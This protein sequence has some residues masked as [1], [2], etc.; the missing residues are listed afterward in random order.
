MT[1]MPAVV[2][3]AWTALA[4][5]KALG[6]ASRLFRMRPR[7]GVDC[8]AP[9][10]CS[11]AELLPPRGVAQ[12]RLH[13][14]V[15]GYSIPD[16]IARPR[17]IAVAP[18]NAA[19][20]E[21]VS[22]TAAAGQF[23]ALPAIRGLHC[24]SS[25]FSPAPVKRAVCMTLPDGVS[26]QVAPWWIADLASVPSIPLASAPVFRPVSD[27][28]QPRISER[29][30][31]ARPRA[32]VI[33]E[34]GLAAVPCAAAEQMPELAVPA[35]ALDVTR[36]APQRIDRLFRMRPRAGITGNVAAFTG[37][38]LALA[39]DGRR[40]AAMPRPLRSVIGILTEPPMVKRTLRMRPRGP[41]GS[42]EL[43]MVIIPAAPGGAA[44]SHAYPSAP[45]DV[46]PV[47]RML[48]REYRM[49]PRVGVG[50]QAPPPHVLD[51]SA[52]GPRIS[53]AVPQLRLLARLMPR[54]VDRLYRMRPRTGINSA[55]RTPERALES[56]PLEIVPLVP[57][58]TLR[59]CAPQMSARLYRMRPRNPISC[60]SVS[61]LRL[62]DM[63]MEEVSEIFVMPPVPSLNVVRTFELPRSEKP[64]RLNPPGPTAATGD[65]AGLSGPEPLDPALVARAILQLRFPTITAVIGIVEP[66]KKWQRAARLTRSLLASYF[67]PR[68]WHPAPALRLS[69]CGAAVLTVILIYSAPNSSASSGR[70]AVAQARE[71]STVS[72]LRKTLN[73]RSA[74]DLTESFASGLHDW[75]GGKDWAASW[76]Y[77]D[78]GGVKPGALALYKPSVLLR[79]YTFEFMGQIERKALAFVTRAADIQNYYVVKLVVTRPGPLPEISIVRY[80][81]LEGREAKHVEK[82]LV[83]TVY[84]DAIYRVRTTVQGDTWAFAVNDQVVDSWTDDRL[85]AGGVGLF[86]AKGEKARIY[87]LRVRHQDDT[88]GKVLATI[89]DTGPQATRGTP[90][91]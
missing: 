82:R 57:R 36:P 86:S 53:S 63:G 47:L 44:V 19:T 2:P 78:R 28:R 6:A 80:P 62:I 54:A 23:S 64:T 17:R 65:G 87:D 75:E 91:Q 43:R 21:A 30:F 38:D 74:V 83:M 7:S 37:I 67:N 14:R 60:A 34:A 40:V 11:A 84:N 68:Y 66:E 26:R 59:G 69:S 25:S 89:A 18:R 9:L 48:T 46:R 13:L 1:A 3:P 72:E 76:T 56:V 88:I 42:A 85:A 39:S 73:A 31:R 70:N 79:N 77:D 8:E 35:A 58:N 15:I 55:S 71:T 27:A 52:F 12:P 5:G 81:V 24:L 32:D 49:R 4:S 61:L 16:M 10:W 90:V 22:I 20:A 45:R 29:L 41:V 50:G 51:S 33:R